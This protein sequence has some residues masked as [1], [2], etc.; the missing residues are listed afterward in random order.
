MSSCNP[1]I[2]Q[3]LRFCQ[4]SFLLRFGSQPKCLSDFMYAYLFHQITNIYMVGS[5]LG[6]FHFCMLPKSEYKALLIAYFSHMLVDLKVNHRYC[7]QTKNKQKKKLNFPNQ[8]LTLHC[9]MARSLSIISHVFLQQ[10]TSVQRRYI[11][12]R[13]P[14]NV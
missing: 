5:M 4:N 9:K 10:L 11:N 2:R 7:K 6:F 12:P 13:L 3:F 1:L 8:T 14:K